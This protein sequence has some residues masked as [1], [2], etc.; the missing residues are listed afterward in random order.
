ASFGTGSS[1]M[2][3]DGRVYLQRC[4]EESSGLHVFQIDS[5]KKVWSV[6][7][8]S[9]TSWSTPYLWRNSNREV[10]VIGGSGSLT[11][12]HPASGDKLWRMNGIPASFTSSPVADGDRL[13]FGT[14]SPFTASAMYAL[15]STADGDIEANPKTIE[16]GKDRSESI[17]WF[18]S[19]APIGMASPVVTHGL[20][21]IP[22]GSGKLR[23]LD[24]K[25]G[26]EVFRARLPQGKEIVASP[27]A[28]NGK[29]FILDEDGRT[30]VIQ[31]GREFKL[32]H[33]NRI[34]DTFWS[35]PAIA[36]K[37]L[38]LRGVDALY[39]IRGK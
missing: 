35:T 32:L 31:T 33:V 2:M 36:G 4:N 24:S 37:D 13:L 27:W 12:Y 11:G 6:D 14:N 7:P 19:K 18:T 22:S 15:T 28:G 23:V 29:V 9:S 16:N 5:G 10:V 1:L 8:K 30:Y 20:M 38:L 25:T 26:E 3:H 39:C 21:Y 34:E 17:G